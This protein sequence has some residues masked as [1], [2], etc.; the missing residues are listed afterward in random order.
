MNDWARQRI[1]FRIRQ[2]CWIILYLWLRLMQA[3]SVVTG[4]IALIGEQATGT[5]FG[6]FILIKFGG[7]IVCFLLFQTLSFLI[8]ETENYTIAKGY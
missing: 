8:R 2:V 6:T 5:S 3:L 4:G 1:S 7:M